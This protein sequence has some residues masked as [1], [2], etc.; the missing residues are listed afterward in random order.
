MR[1]LVSKPPWPPLVVC[2]HL[3]AI[4]STGNEISWGIHEQE[5]GQGNIDIHSDIQS[6]CE[7]GSREAD[8]P[9]AY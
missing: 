9:L 8:V 4:F 1:V 3:H 2:G 6:N 7:V 5:A